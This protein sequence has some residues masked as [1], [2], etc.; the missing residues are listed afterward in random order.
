M[1]L[2]R[3]YA[4]YYNATCYS[5]V[6]HVKSNISEPTGELVHLS[7]YM[8]RSHLFHG[9]PLFSFKMQ[10]SGYAGTPNLTFIFPN[11]GCQ[12][13]DNTGVYES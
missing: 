3:G 5:E 1:A 9:L 6:A 7:D 11:F 13:T 2:L 8:K 10:L 12:M 4:T